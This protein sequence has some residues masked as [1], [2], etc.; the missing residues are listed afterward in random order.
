MSSCETLMNE[1]NASYKGA[2]DTVSV[3]TMLRD[4]SLLKVLILS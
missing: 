3:T 2:S 4:L 1:K